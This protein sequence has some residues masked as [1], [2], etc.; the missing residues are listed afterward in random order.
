MSHD[1]GTRRFEEAAERLSRDRHRF[2]L[3]VNGASSRSAEAL[4]KIRALCDEYLGGRYDLEVVDINQQ[5]ELA[6]GRS[7]IALPTLVREHPPPVRVVV[8][9]L[10]DSD[11]VRRELD[12]E[13]PDDASWGVGG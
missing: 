12:L 6:V 8:G 9:D 4:T 13:P 7:V 10:S 11:R 5:P 2:V 1:E 3:F